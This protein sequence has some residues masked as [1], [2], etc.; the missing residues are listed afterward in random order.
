MLQEFPKRS[1]ESVESSSK[2]ARRVARELNGFDGSPT[3][4]F[5]QLG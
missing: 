2:S 3:S 4:E 1:A 5:G